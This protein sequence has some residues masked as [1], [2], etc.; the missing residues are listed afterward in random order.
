[1]G[2]PN[3]LDHMQFHIYI[4]IKRFEHSLLKDT[5]CLV[6][7]HMDKHEVSCHMAEIN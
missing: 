6:C 7:L 1:M 5:M 4:F 3:N 2:R